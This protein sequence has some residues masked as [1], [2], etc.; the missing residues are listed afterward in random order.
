[1][2]GGVPLE[3]KKDPEKDLDD[4]IFADEEYYPSDR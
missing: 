3:D 4:M 2:R 1:M